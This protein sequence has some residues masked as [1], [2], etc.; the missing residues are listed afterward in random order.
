[1]T[2]NIKLSLLTISFYHAILYAVP[3]LHFFSL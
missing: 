3:R 1:V 2:V